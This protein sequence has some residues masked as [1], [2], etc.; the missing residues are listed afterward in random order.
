MSKYSKKYKGAAL[1]EY[2]LVVALIALAA[3]TIMTTLGGTI[4]TLFTT[5][6]TDIT[7]A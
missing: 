7:G 5:I 3:I 1:I 4:K 2:V 6:N